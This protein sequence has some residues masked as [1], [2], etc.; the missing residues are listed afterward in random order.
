VYYKVQ[1]TIPNVSYPTILLST[2]Y[3]LSRNPQGRLGSSMPLNRTVS[4]ELVGDFISSYP[5]M[6]RDPVEP[7]CV[8][9]RDIIQRD[10]GVTEYGMLPFEGLE[11][12]IK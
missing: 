10:M 11:M 4:C 7:H 9:G 2:Y 6:L 1:A 5:I 3:V 8:P 12:T